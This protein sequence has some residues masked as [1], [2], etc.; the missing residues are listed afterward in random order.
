[1][2]LE[3]TEVEYNMCL[4]AVMK[5]NLLHEITKSNLPMSPLTKKNLGFPDLTEEE[6]ETLTTKLCK[7]S[8][9]AWLKSQPK[10]IE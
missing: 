4:M 5:C 3:L 7:C 8:E 2:D 9:L 6:L 10:V 1:M